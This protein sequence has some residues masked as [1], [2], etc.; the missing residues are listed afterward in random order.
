LITRVQLLSL[1]V[2]D[3]AIARR[4]AVGGLHR[5]HRGVF[6][7]GHTAMAPL[8]HELAAL[9][10]IGDGATLSH[11]SAASAW[12]V[13]KPDD[14]VHVTTAERRPRNRPGIRSHHAPLPPND[15]RT[16]HGLRLTSPQRTL[17]DLAA[18]LSPAALQRATNEAEVL[19]LIS[20]TT[21][22]PGL[23]RSE[24]ERKLLNL[25]HRAGLPPTATNTKVHAHEVDV[26]YEP[27]RLIVEMDGFAYHRT[28]TQTH[29][30]HARDATLLANGYR[31]LRIDWHQLTQTPEALI[32]DL[33]RTLARTG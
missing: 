19:G 22:K 31:V 30:D 27:Q 20:I 21:D 10:A 32:A 17:K 33:A 13:A 18:F 11:H 26:L 9:L 25:L 6:L 23:T 3:R 4:V 12:R 15:V 8:A 5:I 1:G 2:S 7:V 29:R 24:A 16:H 14:I 28:P